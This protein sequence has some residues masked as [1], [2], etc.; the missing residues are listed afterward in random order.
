M[1]ISKILTFATYICVFLAGYMVKS[2]SEGKKMYLDTTIMDEDISDKWIAI[3]R[4][5]QDSHGLFITEQDL[6]WEENNYL[7][8]RGYE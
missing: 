1:L 7:K 4:I 3:Q 6:A 8:Q 2:Q 5:R